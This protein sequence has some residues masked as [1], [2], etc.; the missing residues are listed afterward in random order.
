MSRTWTAADRDE[1]EVASAEAWDAAESTRERAMHFLL[2]VQDAAQA[3]RPWALALLGDFLESGAAS[4]LKR[5]RKASHKVVA[6]APDGRI[7]SRPRTV[8]VQRKTADGVV[9]VQQEA[10]DL[11]AWEEIE[12]KIADFRIQIGAYADNIFILSTVLELR[13]LA[14]GSSTPDEAA[15][16]LGTTVDAWLDTRTAA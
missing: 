9:Y 1:Y 15:R 12:R 7:L 10:F 4:E 16:Q 13:E 5:W 2:L 6:L 11:L 14:P 3:H 8:G